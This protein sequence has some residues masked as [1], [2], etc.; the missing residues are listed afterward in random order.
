MTSLHGYDDELDFYIGFGS[1]QMV[2]HM[3]K[4]LEIDYLWI[5][6]F[7]CCLA[8]ILFFFI[9]ENRNFIL[10]CFFVLKI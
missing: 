4:I 3:A 1:A 6:Y 10:L 5:A 7:R 2:N 9:K 8:S